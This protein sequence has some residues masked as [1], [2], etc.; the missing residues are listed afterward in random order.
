MLEIC[1]DLKR[2]L[3]EAL[4]NIPEEHMSK[5]NDIKKLNFNSSD[6]I[7]LSNNYLTAYLEAATQWM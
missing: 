7:I 1:G 5:R 3:T 4:K 2:Y 6:Y